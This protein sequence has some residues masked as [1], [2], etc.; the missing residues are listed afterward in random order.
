MSTDNE[1]MIAMH[2]VG[3]QLAKVWKQRE[4]LNG[5]LLISGGIIA[6]FFIIGTLSPMIAPHDPLKMFYQDILST[7][8]AEHWLGTDQMGRGLLSRLIYGARASL[9]ISF[10]SVA[11]ATLIGTTLGIVAAYYGGIV[12]MV[13]MR[14]MD[15]IL[16]L[17]MMILTIAVVAFLGNSIPNLIIVIGILYIPGTARIVYTTALSVKQSQYVEAAQT[18]GATGLRIMFRHIL[19]NSLAP[20]F[21][22][23]TL[24]L[25]FV[26]LLE[27]GLS[28]LGLGPPPPTPTWGQMI[29]VGRTYIHMQPM[30]IIAPM[31]ALSIV[32]VALNVFGDALRDVLDP[33]LRTR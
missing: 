11:M 5:R 4:W 15:L 19:P 21:I 29:S 25:G 24:S 1:F 26:I 3:R 27:S 9:Q 17:P 14:T 12:D 28:F 18:L 20:L 10:F 23:I 8:S 31:L 32:I 6:L 16:C 2:R 22:H 33:R 13:I 7:P 30:L